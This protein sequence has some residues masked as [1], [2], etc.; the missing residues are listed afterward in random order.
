MKHKRNI[1]DMMAILADF[2]QS[3]D[4]C[5]IILEGTYNE[6]MR[7][8]RALYE[9]A[10]ISFRRALKNGSTRRPEFGNSLWKFE[11]ENHTEAVNGM[12]DEKVELLK[13]ADKCV[14]HRAVEEARVVE[15]PDDEGTGDEIVKTRYRERIDL[16]PNLRD[17]TKGYIDLLQVKLI[18]RE[19]IASGKIDLNAKK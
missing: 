12:N 14:A 4:C 7:I 6:N 10:L 5:K 8:K 2:E 16:L 11:T 17:I 13:I 1:A 9:S 18:P 3:H 19:L 15:F